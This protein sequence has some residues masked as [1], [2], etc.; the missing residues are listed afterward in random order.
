M[1]RPSL[2][3]PATARATPRGSRRRL[4]VLAG[5]ALV[6]VVALALPACAQT[7][8]SGGTQQRG[9]HRQRDRPRPAPWPT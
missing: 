9:Q 4:P 1:N 3:T 6:A 7:S 2:F 8:S 5:G